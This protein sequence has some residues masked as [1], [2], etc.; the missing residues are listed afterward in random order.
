M[1]CRGA[2][3]F[4][5]RPNPRAALPWAV[6]E[7]PLHTV[8]LSRTRHHGQVLPLDR[9]RRFWARCGVMYIATV[10]A[11]L[12]SASLTVGLYLMKRAADRLPSLQGGWHVPAWLAFI[13]DAE[14]MLG[15]LLQIAGYAVYLWTLRAA[16]LSIV[17]TALNGGIVLFVILAVIGLG[18]R[19]RPIEWVGVCV[20]AAALILLSLSLSEDPTATGAATRVLPFSLA[21][22]GCSVL[23]LAVDQSRQRPIGLAIASGL[24]LGLASVYAKELAVQVSVTAAGLTLV[25]NMVGFAFMQG[26]LQAGRGVVVMP[27]FS[28][29]SNLV[30]IA[31]GLLLFGER[32][33]DH[34]A[35]AVL[36]PSA[37][38]LAIVGAA[39][40]AGFDRSGSAEDTG[41]R[42]A[43]AASSQ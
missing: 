9:V 2:S 20:I 35:N 8:F 7:P 17:H 16:P 15:L 28:V 29:L 6:P 10:L 11:I 19:P 30:P 32:L 18:E 4:V 43:E 25:A 40:L 1:V 27:L 42:Q 22:V 21:M 34:G 39:C 38:V 36:R 26:A 31:A 3:A 24:L 13:R 12:A 37:F 33:P 41:C 5:A 23:A 14:W